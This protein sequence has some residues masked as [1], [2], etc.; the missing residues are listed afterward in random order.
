MKRAKKISSAL[1][2]A[3]MS[4]LIAIPAM[5]AEVSSEKYTYT[6]S[7]EVGSQSETIKL[8]EYDGNQEFRDI[9]SYMDNKIILVKDGAEIKF[10]PKQSITAGVRYYDV[11]GVYSGNL[12][13][14]VDGKEVTDV[15]TNKTG[16]TTL[17][18]RY[19]GYTCDLYYVFYIEEAGNISRIIY[20]VVDDNYTPPAPVT[21]APQTV[22]AAAT[23]SKVLVDGKEVSFEAYNINDNNYFKLRDIAMAV[24]DTSKSFEIGWDGENNAIKLTSGETYT[25]VGGELAASSNPTYKQAELSTSKVY[26]DGKEIKLTAYTIGG[27]NYFKL[28]DLGQALDIIIAWDAETSTIGINTTETNII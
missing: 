27:N 6:L 12:F 16:T 19:G 25:A 13:W 21:P 24:N 4:L 17:H 9:L 18:K 3:I 23:T 8:E 26:L 2:V 15:D 7:G 14:T 28:R 20:K 1:L 10:T 22:T 5:A 11:E